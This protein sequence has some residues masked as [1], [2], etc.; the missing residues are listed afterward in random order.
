MNA[1]VVA[2]IG[3]PGAGKSRIASTLQDTLG[4]HRICRDA[5]RAAMFPGCSFSPAEKRAAFRALLTALEVNCALGRSSVLDGMTFA[6]RADLE[7]VD[8]AIGAYPV[9]ALPIFVDCPPELARE[10]IEADRSRHPARDRVPQLVDQVMARFEPPP[11]GCAVVDARLPAAEMCEAA[12]ALVAA[13]LDW[14]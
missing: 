10:R 2:L 11:A 4:L 7:A 8:R 12:V 5:I 14:R 3:L 13:A 9:R 1:V 6:R